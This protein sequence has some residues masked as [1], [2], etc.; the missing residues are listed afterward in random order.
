M[1]T[2]N[3]SLQKQVATFKIEGDIVTFA[4]GA[5]ILQEV[6]TNF[7]NLSENVL[8]ASLLACKGAKVTILEDG[9]IFKFSICPERGGIKAES[10]NPIN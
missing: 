4:E 1:T 3:I 9:K 5:P 10:V 2:I 6:P 8:Y 7:L